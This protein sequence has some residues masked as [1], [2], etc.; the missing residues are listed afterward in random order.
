[1]KEMRKRERMEGI[2]HYLDAT[3]FYIEKKKVNEG[4]RK[5][6]LLKWKERNGKKEKGPLRV[7]HIS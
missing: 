3:E 2:S 7:F 6:R 1:M 4:K 5:R